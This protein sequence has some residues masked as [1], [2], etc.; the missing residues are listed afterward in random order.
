MQDKAKIERPSAT[1]H[2][3]SGGWWL[4]AVPGMIWGASFLFIAEGMQA[5]GPSGVT[6]VR[7]LLGFATLSLFPSARRPVKRSDWAGIA[8]LGVLWMAFPLSMFP[9]AEQHVSS[10][11]TGMLNGANPL[12]TAAVAAIIARRMP[13]RRIVTGLVVG[14]SG[15]VLMALAPGGVG[16]SSAAGIGM[17]IAAL[18]SYG[19]ALNIASPLQQR[20]GA[21]AVIWR[22]QIVALLLTAPLGV[23]ALMA[24][25]WMTG[26]ATALLALGVLGTGVAYVVMSV[27][28]GKLGATRAS[29]TTFLIP[30]VALVLG[31]IIRHEKVALISVIG[32]IV[33][34]AGAWF[35]RR[36][37]NTEEGKQ[38]SDLRSEKEL[39]RTRAALET[40][41]L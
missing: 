14:M 6:F 32:S 38:R 30:A 28:A 40:G 3:A 9:F 27:A 29:S 4:I 8:W 37:P 23:P 41:E 34:V 39:L 11:L 2:T 12:F 20:N 33:C 21:L 15:A 1:L 26:P 18:T 19:I 24:A 16:R 7:I 13:S 25:R 36:A 31:V 17:I 10:A 35:M 5:I 22:A